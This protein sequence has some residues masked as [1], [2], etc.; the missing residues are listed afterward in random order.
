MGRGPKKASTNHALGG[1]TPPSIR[2]PGT[3]TQT[4]YRSP[5]DLGTTCQKM[6]DWPARS[7]ETDTTLSSGCGHLHLG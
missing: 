3:K 5:N 4:T 1:R 7:S 2:L 6:S